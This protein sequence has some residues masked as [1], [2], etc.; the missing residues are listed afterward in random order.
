MF[1]KG[2]LRFSLLINLL[3]TPI[4]G[5]YLVKKYQFYQ[6]MKRDSEQKN[7]AKNQPN[8]YWRT[9]EAIYEMLPGKQKAIVFMGNSLVDF[10][11]W[12]ELFDRPI[13]NRGLAGDTMDGILR[14]V[15][16]VTRFKPA[17]IFLLVCTN[18][19]PGPSTNLDTICTKY[20]RLIKR[21]RT[22]DSNCKIYIISE[23]PRWDSSSIARLILPLNDKLF[24]LAKTENVNFINVYDKLATKDGLLSRQFS[25]DGLHMNGKGYLILKNSI[26]PYIN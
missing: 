23:L 18:D 26:E 11:E 19:L 21:I 16:Q 13:I 5:L 10:C 4:A 12:S 25:F 8:S 20:Q 6:D 14:R 24:S 1:D 7:Y 15:D 3:L 17:K 2:F 9:R 22:G